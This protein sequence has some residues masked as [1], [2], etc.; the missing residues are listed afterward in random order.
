[1]VTIEGNGTIKTIFVSKYLSGNIGRPQII[2]N[3]NFMEGVIDED[4]EIMFFL[5]LDLF[6][7]GMITLLD[8]AVVE[9]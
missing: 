4:E 1:M 6:S 2:V 8:Q 7:I 9:P 3:Y 5:K